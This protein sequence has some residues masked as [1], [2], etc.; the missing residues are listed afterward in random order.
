MAQATLM[1]ATQN[2]GMQMP[3][4]QQLQGA[5]FKQAGAA[6]THADPHAPWFASTSMHPGPQAI[7]VTCVQSTAC[8]VYPLPPA[9]GC[10]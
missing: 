5:A 7:L 6:M 2:Q 3:A 4:A 8:P 10:P 9:Q 1:Q